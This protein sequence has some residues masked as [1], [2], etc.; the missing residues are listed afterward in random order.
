[1]RIFHSP[2]RQEATFLP[3]K[4]RL[5]FWVDKNFVFL[6]NCSHES[7]KIMGVHKRSVGQSRDVSQSDLLG[8]LLASKVSIRTKR[9]GR[10]AL[11]LEK[12]KHENDVREAESCHEVF[13]NNLIIFNYRQ[14]IFRKSDFFSTSQ[15]FF[16]LQVLLQKQNIPARHRTSLGVSIRAECKR[17]AN[18]QSEFPSMRNSAQ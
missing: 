9:R 10:E 15:F 18:G 6:A 14:R 16:L 13:F 17:L 1:M 8:R 3:P 12:R 11:G 5:I 2:D 7:R 4:N